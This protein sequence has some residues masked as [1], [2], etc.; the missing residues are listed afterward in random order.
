MLDSFTSRIFDSTHRLLNNVTLTD[1]FLL[2]DR[3]LPVGQKQMSLC[4][5]CDS[6]VK[7]FLDKS[8]K[9]YIKKS[10]HKMTNDE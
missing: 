7:S 9:K 10:K 5:L 4:V 3:Y 1:E 6:A 8:E 2:S